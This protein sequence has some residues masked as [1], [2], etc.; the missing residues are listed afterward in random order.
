VK[1][2]HII[3]LV[4]LAYLIGGGIPANAMADEG[5][6]GGILALPLNPEQMVTARLTL[7]RC[8][9]YEPLI[10]RWNVEFQLPKSLV[11]AIM[12]K[13]SSCF[14]YVDDGTSVGLMQ[15]TPASW[16]TTRERLMDPAVNVYWGMR[17]LWL[18]INHDEHNPEHDVAKALA[19]YNC[20]WNDTGCGT[21]YASDILT[22]WLP[23]AERYTDRG[24]GGLLP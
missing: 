22:V 7:W 23:L 11:I 24:W 14:P 21:Q 18:T 12:A 16:T 19:A 6:G 15:V 10:D 17:I 3:V 9:Q 8:Y 20:D 2:K 1:L 4:L 5:G 13:E